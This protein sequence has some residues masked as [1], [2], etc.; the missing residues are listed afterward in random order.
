MLDLPELSAFRWTVCDSVEALSAL[1]G[2]DVGIRVLGEAEVDGFD[3]WV[4]CLPPA[5]RSCAWL[6]VL[7]GAEESSQDLPERLKVAECLLAL[8]KAPELAGAIRRLGENQRLNARHRELEDTIRIMD[9]CQVLTR[10]LEFDQLYPELLE[11][12][13]KV[14]GGSK[15]IAFFPRATPAKGMKV[16]L[17][18]FG[19]EDAERVTSVLS[20]GEGVASSAESGVSIRS[21]SPLHEALQQAGFSLDSAFLMGLGHSTEEAGLVAIA[22][23]DLAFSELDKRRAEIVFRHAQMAMEN[24]A[25]YRS[26]QEH[27][28]IDDVTGVYNIRYFMDICEKELR[29]SARYSVP[30]SLLFLDLDQFKR[31]NEELGHV[32]GSQVLNRLCQFLKQHVRQVDTLARYGGDEFAILLVGTDHVEALAIAERIRVAVESDRVLLGEGASLEL[33]LSIGVATCPDHG[34]E[35]DAFI[36]AADRAMFQAKASGRNCVFSVNELS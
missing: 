25:V 28:F 1:S 35:R 32:Q 15:G 7:S 5:L 11:L 14:V 17:R 30:L 19:E 27:A 13:L 10:C 26:A 24:A 33:T 2:F 12:L 8:P 23:G 3:T 36:E 31:I 20:A 16:V 29:R 21:Q 18:G 34:L 22:G 9:A 6:V 4:S